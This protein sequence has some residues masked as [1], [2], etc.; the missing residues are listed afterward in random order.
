M[1]WH[2]AYRAFPLLVLIAATG[3]DGHEPLAPLF[4]VVGAPAN[5][6]ATAISFSQ[7]SLS[8]QDNANSPNESGFEVHRSSTGPAGSFG[9]IGTAGPQA[10]SYSD[11]GLT[12]LTQYCYKVRAYRVT[13]KKT[14]YSEF[15]AVACATTP[16]APVPTAPSAVN[17]APFQGYRIDIAWTDNS[18]DETGFRVEHSPSAT[19][20]W[21][22]L[23][24]AGANATSA[25]DW[26][27]ALE[28]PLCY[29]V[30]GYN[31]YGD[32]D[33]SNVACTAVP[34]AP[35]NLVAS[36]SGTAVD[37]SW[38]NNSTVAGGVEVQRAGEG[39]ISAVIANVDANTAV[40]HDAPPPDNTYT[41][42]VRATEHGGTSGSSNT[43]Q[44]LIAISPPQA[45]TVVDAVPAGSNG[46]S[47][48]WNDASHNE[49]GFRVERSTDGGLSWVA[50]GNTGMNELSFGDYAIEVVSEH[51][52]CYHVIAFNHVG[53]SAPSIRDCTTPPAAP[54]DFT[55]IAID[56]YTVDLTWADNS[57]VAEG[58]Q[59][60][61]DDGYY[62]QYV[63]ADLPAGTTSFQLVGYYAYG[64]L[65]GVAAVKDGGYSDFQWTYAAPPAGVA[66]VRAAPPKAFHPPH[67]RKLTGR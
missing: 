33:P 47:V 51:E 30:F 54:T 34:A 19:G 22:T 21:T 57:A 7:I 5:L 40:Y 65:F 37:L 62:G 56:D 38:T 20:P 31:S 46:V 63:V 35:S 17:A 61:V 67:Q 50:A 36:L 45:P 66:R 29:R 11:A 59:V 14:T 39:E 15:S 10:T 24:T 53:E 27:I 18:A 55:A 4:M 9:F 43:V 32:S 16:R 3:C 26:Q 41:Y 13:G 23:V 25:F 48:A 8:W 49:E 52:F 28:Q 6:T 42:F 44:V 64:Y 12:G 1:T 60:W 2:R 58:Y